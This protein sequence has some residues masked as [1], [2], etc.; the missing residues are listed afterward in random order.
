[1]N[2]MKEFV[3][4]H[5][6]THVD[7]EFNRFKT[8]HDKDYDTHHEHEN[9]KNIFRQNLRFIHSKN[10]QGLGFSLGKKR[11]NKIYYFLCTHSY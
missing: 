8:K 2:P 3:F 7:D 5:D 6:E 4:P 11:I 10:R 9:R 1:M